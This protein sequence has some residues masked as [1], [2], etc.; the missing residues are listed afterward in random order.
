MTKQTTLADLDLAP[1]ATDWMDRPSVQAVM[2]ALGDKARFV[3]GCVR[4]AILGAPVHDIDVAVAAR[5]QDA[6]Q[7][8]KEAGLRV[9]E[10]GLAH[11][12]VTAVTDGEAIEVTSLRADVETDGRHA[13]VRYTDDWDEDWRRRDFTMNAI[14][15]DRS[16]AV[17]DP[18][19]GVADAKAGRVRFIGE[20]A[21]RIQE[22]YLRILRFFRFH[23]WYGRGAMDADALAACARLKGG[24]ADLSGERVRAEL[25]KLLGADAPGET[26]RAMAQAGV[27]PLASPPP[28]DFRALERFADIRRTETGAGGVSAALALA[29]LCPT[30]GDSVADRLRLSRAERQTLAASSAAGGEA[31]APETNAIRRGIYRKGRQTTCAGLMLAWAR[32]AADVADAAWDAALAFAQSEPIPKFPLSGADAMAAGL[33]EGPAIGA[34]LAA[35]E[36]AWIA[37]DFRSDRAALLRELAATASGRSTR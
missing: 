10:T 30:A 19:G 18:A 27:L 2:A 36:D 1:G 17:F 33:P 4:N 14:Y 24:V 7:R 5:P 15:V 16:G 34:A 8:L 9:V 21:D 28:Y 29:A 26:L 13:V 23:A 22:D 37:D 31:A 20:A 3:G 11:G 35:V 6:V 12:T 25:F 32:G